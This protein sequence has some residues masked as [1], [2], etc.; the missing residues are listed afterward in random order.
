[1]LARVFLQRR[2]CIVPPAPLPRK[3]RWLSVRSAADTHM[4]LSDLSICASVARRAPAGEVRVV[5]PSSIV[6]QRV[7]RRGGR[8]RR[9]QHV[10]ILVAAVVQTAGRGTHAL[11]ERGY[12]RI[13]SV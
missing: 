10:W 3:P 8:N 9:N 7:K 11:R 4:S 2:V 6:H 1:M 5:S 12:K 13:Q